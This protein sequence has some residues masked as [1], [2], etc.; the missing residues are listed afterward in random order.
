[1]LFRSGE[2]DTWRVQEYEYNVVSTL[3]VSIS[4]WQ[5]KMLRKFKRVYLGYNT[6]LPGIRATEAAYNALYKH[7][8]VMI[9]GYPE[10]DADMCSLQEFKE[11]FENPFNYAEFKLLTGI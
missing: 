8:D 6:D 1:M 10:K 4:E 9:L 2:T 3:G 5:N 11:V 7:T